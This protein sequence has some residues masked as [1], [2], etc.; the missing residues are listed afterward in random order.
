[1]QKFLK[2]LSTTLIFLVAFLPISSWSKTADPTAKPEKIPYQQFSDEEFEA[3][4]TSSVE[5]YDPLEKANRKVF[6]FNNAFD[7][8]FFEHVAK[9]YRAG[10]PKTARNSVRNFLVNLS[11]PLSAVNSILQGKSDNALAT[12]SNFLINST[13][14]VGGLFD[15][16]SKKGIIYKTEDFGQT[17]GHYGTG[18]GSYLMIPFLGPSST[19]D[20]SGWAVDKSVDPLG[21]NFLEI[22]GNEDLIESHNRIILA[23]VSGIDSRES[24]IDILDDVRRD[25]FDPYATI[26]SAYLQKRNTDVKN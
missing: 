21:F 24:L 17:L 16:A 22:G 23:A 14:G 2:K 26:R 13:L 25:S 15:V 8:Y 18:T 19:R 4:E 1:M 11:A 20:F 5:I 10:V 12:I 6:T 7:R 9:A 3:Y